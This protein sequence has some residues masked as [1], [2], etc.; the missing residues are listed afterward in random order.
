[1]RL[2]LG[3]NLQV[4]TIRIRKDNGQSQVRVVLPYIVNPSVVSIL[5]WPVLEL[6]ASDS[7]IVHL[8][9]SKRPYIAKPFFIS[10]I[11]YFTVYNSK[12]TCHKNDL[13]CH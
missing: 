13:I 2:A 4:K 11:K 5:G 10:E 12:S 1:L 9:G 3:N 6:T 8:K 7:N